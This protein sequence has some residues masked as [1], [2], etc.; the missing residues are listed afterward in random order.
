MTPNVKAVVGDEIKLLMADD[1][2]GVAVTF[3]GEASEMLDNNKDLD[4]V[5]PTQGSNLWFDN[6]VIPK[7]AKNI[8]GAH[9]FINFMLNPKKCGS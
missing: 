2:A 9:K 7:T 6:M 5:I 8:D 4:Y 3:S 1:E